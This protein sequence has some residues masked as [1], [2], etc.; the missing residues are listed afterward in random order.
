M[1]EHDT[2][3]PPRSSPAVRAT[4]RVPAAVDPSAFL[5]IVT[6]PAGGRTVVAVSGEIDIDTEQ[7]LQ[8]ALRLALARSSEGVDLDLT[9]VG[10][11][12]CSGL[13]VLLRVRR[14]ALTDGKTL[15]IRAAAPG[16]EKLLALTDTSSLFAPARAPVNGVIVHDWHEHS[17][18]THD[19]ME[20][21][22]VSDEAEELRVEVVQLKR[23]M[24]TRP[25]IDLARGVLM[26]SFGL[27]PE[28]AWNVLV[29]V[30]QRTNTKLHQLAEELVESVNGQ[31]LSPPLRQQLSAAV[32]AVSDPA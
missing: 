10:F 8:R 26:A 32:D 17:A 5:E 16:V 23:A 27:S 4:Q 1:P 6:R 11:C 14:I 7:T 25:V 24:L 18:A 15:R 9:G 30:S 13:N 12:D 28:D 21:N 2:S 31:P 22:G 3:A 19:L 20:E 29:D